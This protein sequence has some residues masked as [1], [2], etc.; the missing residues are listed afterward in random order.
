MEGPLLNERDAV[1]C[2]S[3]EAGAYDLLRDHCVGVHPF[4][5]SQTAR[6]FETA[7]MMDADE[8]ATRA[9]GLRTASLAHP[10]D[11]WLS[12][13]VARATPARVTR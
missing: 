12:D 1:L 9:V 6:A 8:R 7:L 5:V 3:H 4:D 2:L 13:L 10:A 11:R